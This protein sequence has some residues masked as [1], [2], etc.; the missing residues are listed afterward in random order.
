[1]NIVILQGIAVANV[2]PRRSKSTDDRWLEH[3]APNPVPLG[4]IF[5]PYYTRRKSTTKLSN[6]KDFINGKASKY[7]LVAQGADTD[8]ELETRLYKGNIIPTCA[9]GAQVVFNDVECLKQLSPVK[10]PLRKRPSIDEPTNN[11][12][13][14]SS[15]CSVGIQG[16][17]T[18]Y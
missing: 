15:R 3:R 18:K 13:E 1:M 7:C 16:K 17:K 2:R 11:P 14:I 5:Q 9:G 4:T 10:S 12:D 8:G 6:A